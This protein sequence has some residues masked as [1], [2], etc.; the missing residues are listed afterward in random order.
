MMLVSHYD[1]PHVWPKVVHWLEAAVKIN[2]GD[3]NLFDVGMAI[4]NGLYELW[5]QKDRFAAVVQIQDFPRQRVAVI[6]Y[7][8]GELESLKEMY[9]EAKAVAKARGIDVLRVWGRAGWERTLGLKRIGVIL[10]E[11]L[12]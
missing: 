6:A 2:Q 12:S 10:Q 4:E 8:G 11:K 9:Q 1:L 7:A 5:Y 3:E